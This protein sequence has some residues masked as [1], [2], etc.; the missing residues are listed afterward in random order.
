MAFK[1]RHYHVTKRAFQI[2]C[3]D[4]G[5]LILF[6][7]CA[8]CGAK[9]L[10]SLPIY[11]KPQRHICD[12]YLRPQHKVIQ[13]PGWMAPKPEI[14]RAA[15][16]IDELKMYE[17]PIC[18]KIFRT[19]SDL[20]QHIQQLKKI[21]DEHS[22]FFESIFKEVDFGLEDEQSSNN[23]L[24]HEP[25]DSAANEQSGSIGIDSMIPNKDSTNFKKD[26]DAKQDNTIGFGRVVMKQR[27]KSR[28][29]DNDK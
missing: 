11:G 29:S 24:K 3:K 20:N 2:K 8:A 6:W 26:F 25:S 21:E 17:C 19:D 23:D 27:K 5:K 4:C 18:N 1:P 12:K 14:E 16:D 10:F 22:R 9:A 13:N 28:S 15:L 7:E